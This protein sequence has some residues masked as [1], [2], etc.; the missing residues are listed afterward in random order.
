[1]HRR[2]NSY[3]YT[4]SD[5]NKVVP[6]PL[7]L[8][9]KLDTQRSEEFIKNTEER[10]S[11]RKNTSSLSANKGY[12]TLGIS[13]AQ[14]ALIR[15]SVNFEDTDM[16]RPRSPVKTKGGKQSSDA[17]H[18]VPSLDNALAEIQEQLVSITT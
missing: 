3:S 15:F 8:S 10:R 16:H 6:P 1:M 18:S 5:L 7:I 9:K 14:P 13:Q 2:T 12:R 4:A 17:G 11:Y